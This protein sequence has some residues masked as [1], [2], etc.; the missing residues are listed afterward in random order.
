TTDNDSRTD[1]R[2]RMLAL[3]DRL[4][5]ELDTAPPAYVASI[6]RQLQAVLKELAGMPD[7]DAPDLAAELRARRDARLASYRTQPDA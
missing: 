2:T 3:R 5:V 1:H 6:A 4:T 7:P